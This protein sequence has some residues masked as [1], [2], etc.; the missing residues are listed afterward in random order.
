[1]LKDILSEN[2]INLGVEAKDWQDAIRKAANPLIEGNM[3]EESYVENMINVVHELGPYIVIMPGVAFAHARPDESVHKTCISL[4]TLKNPVN[5][6]SVANDP[7]SVIFTFAAKNSN[8]HV[9]ALQEVATFLM[10]KE[11]VEM[12]K[13]STNRSEIL[14]RILN[15]KEVE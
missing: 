11:N 3:I 15:A 8:T 13:T 4:A 12:L 6:G 9:M 10:I 2:M 7:V 14:D 5:F 1:M